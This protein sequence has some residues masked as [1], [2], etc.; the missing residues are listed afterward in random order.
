M[1]GK[2]LTRSD[3]GTWKVFFNRAHI[4]RIEYIE[5]LRVS[6]SNAW[7]T[8]ELLEGGKLGE[9]LASGEW[10]GSA[11][12][13]PIEISYKNQHLYHQDVA[14]KV[15]HLTKLTLPV[16]TMGDVTDKNYWNNVYPVQIRIGGGAS[17]YGHNESSAWFIRQIFDRGKMGNLIDHGTIFDLFNTKFLYAK[18]TKTGSC[19]EYVHITIRL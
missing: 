11:I 14:T 4:Y 8:Y 7:G 3:S 19:E 10:S 15:F 2:M 12:N 9:K 5:Y 1:E 17:F 13:F 16:G 6:N 18:N